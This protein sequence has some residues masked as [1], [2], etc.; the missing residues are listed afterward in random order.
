M[1]KNDQEISSSRNSLYQNPEIPKQLVWLVIS[2][3]IAGVLEKATSTFDN[4]LTNPFGMGDYLIN[5]SDKN[6]PLA[7]IPFLLLVGVIAL[8]ASMFLGD[9]IY[10]FITFCIISIIVLILVIFRFWEKANRTKEKKKD[11]HWR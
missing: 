9:A 11:S 4:V 8:I 3:R 6:D 10:G 1:T 2:E 5:I 7:Y